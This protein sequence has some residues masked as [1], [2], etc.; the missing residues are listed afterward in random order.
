M[1]TSGVYTSFRSCWRLWET[2]LAEY[3]LTGQTIVK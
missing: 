3:S 1:N 2:S